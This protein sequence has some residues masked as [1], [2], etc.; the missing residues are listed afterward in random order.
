M[1]SNKTL[2]VK[3]STWEM[4]GGSVYSILWVDDL[5]V[6]FLRLSLYYHPEKP[7]CNLKMALEKEN[8]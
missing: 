7:T 1:T 6:I 8:I 4:I 5:F 3:I 2:W